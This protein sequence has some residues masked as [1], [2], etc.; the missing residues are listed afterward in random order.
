MSY[1]IT[2]SLRSSSVIRFVEPGTY[3]VQLANLSS[4]IS[5]EVV[6]SASIKRLLWSTNGNI[7]I[8]RNSVKIAD[9]YHSG[10]MVFTELGH[11]VAN[12]STSSIVVTVTTGGTLFMEVTKD[13]TYNPAL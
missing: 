11:S 7:S 10:E 13:T 2:N 1:E 4:N 8:T 3:T 5:T 12:N 6:N 9:L